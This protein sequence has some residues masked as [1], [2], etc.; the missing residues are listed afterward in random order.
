MKKSIRQ[1]LFEELDVSLSAFGS[2]SK[3]ISI[4]Y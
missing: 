1:T 4:D 2:E 3:K